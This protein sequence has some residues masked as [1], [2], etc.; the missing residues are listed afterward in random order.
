MSLDEMIDSFRN[1]ADLP[2]EVA[3]QAAP[4][5]EARLKA[6]AAAGTSPDGKA[7]AVKKDGG[8]AMVNAAAAISVRAI[9]LVVRVTL[10]GVEVYHQFS[11]K[12][13]EPRRPI[14]P[15]AGG[16]MPKVVQDVLEQATEKAMRR[17][18]GLA[19]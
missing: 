7:W 13:G 1:L 6:S 14:I 8:R 2:T 17:I 12:K 16:P 9:G 3:K 11:K 4:L 19:P 18:L 15:D 10:A 5:L